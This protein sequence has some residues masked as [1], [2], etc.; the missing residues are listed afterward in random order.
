MP[1]QDEP[2]NF[3]LGEWIEKSK[4]YWYLFVVAG[5]IAVGFIVFTNLQ[6]T[7]TYKVAGRLMVNHNQQ[8][9]TLPNS[10]NVNS[11]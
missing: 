3:H 11:R 8:K 2:S 9:N 6:W 4:R 5:I 7:P 10:S 1:F